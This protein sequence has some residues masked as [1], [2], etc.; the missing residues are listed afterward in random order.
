MN[1]K[2]GLGKTFDKNLNIHISR[3]IQGLQIR[4][5]TYFAE[6]YPNIGVPTFKG[7]VGKWYVKITKQ[8]ETG[9]GK[10][11]DLSVHSF[12][13]MANGDV[14]MAASWKA[15]AKHARG[16][17]FTNNGQDGATIYGAKYL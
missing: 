17:V 4:T 2:S 9:I 13:D 1:V 8:T 3:Y 10:L 16:N 6:H 7:V 5:N 11:S 15:P 14:L 12:I